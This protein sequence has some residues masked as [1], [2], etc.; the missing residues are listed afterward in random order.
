MTPVVDNTV[1]NLFSISAYSKNKINQYWQSIPQL[2]SS[3][4]SGQ[5]LTNYSNDTIST[6]EY[7]LNWQN[8]I[9]LGP[10]TLQIL[11]ERRVQY[12]YASNSPNGTQG[13]CRPQWSGSDI[14]CIVS[15]NRS[16]N[17]VAGSYQLK[18]GNNLASAS[19]RNDSISSYGSKATGSIAY[20]YFF[21]KR[22]AG[23]YQLRHW[24]SSA[25]L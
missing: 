10:D 9:A 8:N 7:D 22:M 12:V 24:I 11:A 16:T 21:L 15:Q 3:N 2:S 25:N 18:R 23:E 5:N 13:G 19:I 1:N 4:S 20:G 14:P 6:P 17:S